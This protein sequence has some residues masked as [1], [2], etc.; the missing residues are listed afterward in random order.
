MN[1][2]PLWVPLLVAGLSL[3]GTA[4]G[5]IGGVLI[6]QRRADRREDTNW[7]RE[8]ERERALW[9]REDESRTFEHRREAYAEFFESL[10]KSMLFVDEFGMGLLS[11]EIPRGMEMQED[12]LTDTFERLQH[13]EIYGSSRVA[14]L[15]REAY[16]AT[17]HWG[18]KSRYEDLSREFVATRGAASVARDKLLTAIRE[19]LQI[20]DEWTWSVAHPS[21]G[22]A[23]IEPLNFVVW[24]KFRSDVVLTF[25]TSYLIADE[26]E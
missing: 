21:S 12:W 18:S 15:A 20:P 24:Q 5:A 19:E 10:R 23:I 7:K 6:T 14:A 11:P 25:A 16:N 2:S 26:R 1:D 9:S 17:S 13:L 22:S 8:R 4:G 3:L